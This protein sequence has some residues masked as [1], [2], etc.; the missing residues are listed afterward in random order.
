MR[1]DAANDVK[2]NGRQLA[3]PPRAAFDRFP[4]RPFTR[5]IFYFPPIF[6]AVFLAVC[7]FK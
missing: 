7:G 1:A 6:L 3:V 5:P 2:S 4:R